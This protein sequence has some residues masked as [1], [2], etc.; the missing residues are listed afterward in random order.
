MTFYL[1]AKL[2]EPYQFKPRTVERG[3]IWQ[4]IADHLNEIPDLKFRVTK[5]STRK[6]F[7]LLLSKSKAKRREEAKL[8]GVNVEDTELDTAMEE[9]L[10][11]WEAAE[12]DDLF[13]KKKDE[14]DRSKGEDIRLMAC[15]RLSQ[16][17]KRHVQSDEND[18]I[19]EKPKRKSRRYGGD[20]VAF[21]REKAQQDLELKKEDQEIKRK[22][23]ERHSQV[24]ERFLDSQRQ[25]QQQQAQVMNMMQQQSHAMLALMS[26]LA[27]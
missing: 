4:T 7:G 26:K 6:H 17:T 12:K 19:T 24:Y 8:S 23:Q 27:K 25:Q 14:T 2:C 20:T 22:E 21:L 9:V 15:E 13:S 11:K 16:T 1:P 10:E 18:E 3:K 5:R